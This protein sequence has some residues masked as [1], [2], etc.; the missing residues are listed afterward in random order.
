MLL[1]LKLY[2][3]LLKL[4]V[5]P[6]P[7]AAF[8][9]GLGIWSLSWGLV[10][11]P[12]DFSAHPRLLV[13]LFSCFVW[14]FFAE[15]YNVTSVDELFRERTGVRGVLSASF[16]TSAV[17]LGILYFSRSADFPRG[18]FV[19]GMLTL[20]LLAVLLRGAFRA[21]CRS[22][23]DFSLPTRLLIVGA[24]QFAAEAASRLQRL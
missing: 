2:R 4:A 6:L 9:L 10:G 18:V 7:F 8:Y 5:Y 16:A 21:L 23:F 14:A 24:D 11:R 19:L 22:R 13:P 15:Q 12:A 3:L 1:R 17:L 20:L